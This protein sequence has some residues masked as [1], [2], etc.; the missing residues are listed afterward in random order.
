[1][2]YFPE[3]PR[4]PRHMLP[5]EDQAPAREFF[6]PLERFMILFIG[7]V[8]VTFVTGLVLAFSY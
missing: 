5:A 3:E 2:Y 7:S 8:A 1:M 6:D 4:G